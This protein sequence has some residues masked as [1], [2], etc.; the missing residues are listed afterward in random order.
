MKIKLSAPR[1]TIVEVEGKKHLFASQGFIDQFPEL[2]D[3]VF[4]VPELEYGGKEFVEYCERRLSD[5]NAIGKVID[6]PFK[7]ADGEEEVHHPHEGEM[8]PDSPKT[9]GSHD[10][11]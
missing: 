3:H 10:E 4:V 1:L 8:W 9:G 5:F 11:V 6:S 7:I 2:I